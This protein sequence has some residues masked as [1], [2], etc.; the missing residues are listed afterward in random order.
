MRLSRQVTRHGISVPREPY[1][2]EARLD[3]LYRLNEIPVA[4]REHDTS[5]LAFEC[6]TQQ[7]GTNG[8][9]YTTL[10][11]AIA[12]TRT[13]GSLQGEQLHDKSTPFN[14]LVKVVCSMIP[15]HK[16]VVK[17]NLVKP[18]PTLLYCPLL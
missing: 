2:L 17:D 5:E 14:F 7:V 3:N 10:N 6:H 18:T 1:F 11:H 16:R 15:L 4:C 9:V 12:S 13:H 8:H